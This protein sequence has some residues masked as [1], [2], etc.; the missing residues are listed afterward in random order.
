MVMNYRGG[1]LKALI[2]MQNIVEKRDLTFYQGYNRE[3]HTG[4]LTTYLCKSHFPKFCRF[5]AKHTAEMLYWGDMVQFKARVGGALEMLSEVKDCMT[6][7]YHE[8]YK[9]A[10][11]DTA[12]YFTE[13]EGKV[14]KTRI[15]N[16]LRDLMEA[17]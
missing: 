7:D 8:G 9:Q 13:C 12:N 17:V 14:T 6:E 1:Y 15:I 2:D 3:T 16:I 11:L 5:L 4:K 10:L